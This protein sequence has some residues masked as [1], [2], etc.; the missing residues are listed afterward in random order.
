[1]GNR[2]N[3]LRADNPKIKSENWFYCKNCRHIEYS[4]DCEC[5]G[6][7]CNAMACEKHDDIYWEIQ[8]RLKYRLYPYN[9][10]YKNSKTYAV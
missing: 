6:T 1:M 3:W 2:Q 10:K 9:V 8:F 4:F 5:M 7:S